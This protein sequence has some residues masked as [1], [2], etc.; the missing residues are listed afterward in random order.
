MIPASTIPPDQAWFWT[1]GWQAKEREVEEDLAH[2]ERGLVFGDGEA[3]LRFLADDA[4]LDF[5]PLPRP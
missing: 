4:G 1:P 5:P 2:G 3:F